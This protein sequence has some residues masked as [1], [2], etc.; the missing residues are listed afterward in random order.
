MEIRLNSATYVRASIDP[1]NLERNQALLNRS[2][3]HRFYPHPSPLLKGE[4]T[5]ILAPFSL[6]RGVGDEGISYLHSATPEISQLVIQYSLLECDQCAIALMQWLNSQNIPGKI[7]KLKT[8]RRS[9]LYIVSD[10][11]LIHARGL[12]F[13]SRWSGGDGC[14]SPNDE[15]PLTMLICSKTWWMAIIQRHSKSPSFRTISILTLLPLS[16]KHLNR[17]KSAEFWRS[18]SFVTPLNTAVG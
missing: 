3:K 11:I 14:K 16:T 7:L 13:V 2:M 15:L 5:G 8:K 17:Q 1:S 18:W 4:G 9:E 6:G 10:R 12:C